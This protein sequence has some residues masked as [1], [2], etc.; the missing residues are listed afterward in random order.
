MKSS[1]VRAFTLVELLVVIGIIALL[2]SILLP[3]L[4]KARDQANQVAC[5]SNEHQFYNIWQLY[6]ADYRGYAI[7]CVLQ[8]GGSEYDFYDPTIIGAELGKTQFAIGS[9]S[10]GRMQGIAADIKALLTCPGADH[11]ADPNSAMQAAM[12]TVPNSATTSYWGDYLYNEYMGVIKQDSGTGAQFVY[13]P[14]SKTTQIPPSVILMMESAKPN[15]NLP[16]T[17]T[18][19]DGYQYKCYFANWPDLFHNTAGVPQAA[20]A[21]GLTLNRIGTPHS[22]NTKMNVLSA[23]GHI[24]PVVP[25]N[26]F[27][28]SP[29]DER[30]VKQY[31]WDNAL[32]GGVLGTAPAPET[33]PPTG[34][35]LNGGWKHGVPGI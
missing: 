6:A 1:R 24:S 23:D 2:I 19:P 17:G 25:L 12:G 29:L 27:F 22:K 20:S 35:D 34:V 15:Y 14:Y 13:F 3:A 4:N 30:T 7:P 32:T 21:V 11:S 8:A 10:T 31:L 28:S 26:A 5:G 9:S 18:L 16:G 33:P